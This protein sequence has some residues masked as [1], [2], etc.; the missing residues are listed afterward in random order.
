M[1][2]NYFKFKQFTIEQENC[3]MKV[4]TDGCLLGGWFDTT[5]SHEIL[6]I[7]CG[8]GL[9]AIMAAQ[10]SNATVT[11]IEIDCEAAKQATT[12]VNNSPW[13]ERIEIINKD[14][15][16]YSP[17][18]LFDTIVCNP[19]YFI[20]S[21]K[22]DNTSRA[23]ARHSDSLDCNDFFRHAKH[24]STDNAKISIVIPCDILN[25][26][27]TAAHL[28]GFFDKRVT[29]IKTTPRKQP[30]RVLIEFIKGCY[31]T[32]LEHTFVLEDEPGVYSNEATGILRDFYLRFQ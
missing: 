16:E 19:P 28:Y 31:T 4:G 14:F 18:K 17:E 29:Y 13:K 7:G 26:W 11:G 32:P 5:E 22:C 8:S 2:N 21:L 10:R 27:R 1:S 25:E 20:N 6:D 12:N 23:L 3:A 15:L 9:I 24:I 30:K